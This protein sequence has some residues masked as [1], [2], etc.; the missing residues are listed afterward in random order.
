MIESVY[1]A[2]IGAAETAGAKRGTDAAIGFVQSRDHAWLIVESAEMDDHIDDLP[3]LDLSGE[4]ADGTSPRDVLD[5]IAEHMRR[6]SAPINSGMPDHS[7]YLDE[8]HLDPDT[9]GAFVDAYVIGFDLAVEAKIEADAQ[10]I[11]KLQKIETVEG[12]TAYALANMADCG[13]PDDLDSAGAK[14]L[15]SVRDSF[16]ECMQE[17]RLSEE[18]VHEIADGAPDVYTHTRWREFVD[19]A[20]YEEDIEDLSPDVSDLTACAGV[21]LYTIAERLIHALAEEIGADLS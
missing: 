18:I 3:R 17:D 7:D 12:L 5:E 11:V 14:M 16:V 9:A 10:E 21:A 8:A 2:I 1:N 15:I 6:A 4:W 13:C 20:A 19:L